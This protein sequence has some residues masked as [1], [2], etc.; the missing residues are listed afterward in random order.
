[1]IDTKDSIMLMCQ[2]SGEALEVC[3]IKDDSTLARDVT[4]NTG[5]KPAGE[6]DFLFWHCFPFIESFWD[7]I[8]YCLQILWTGR[9]RSYDVLLSSEDA[10]KIVDFIQEKTEEEEPR[11]GKS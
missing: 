9:T 7:R 3:F 8:K 10:R 6:F 4:R 2:C 1:M 5:S 11:Y